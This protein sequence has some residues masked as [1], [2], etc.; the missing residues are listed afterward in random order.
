MI[1]ALERRDAATLRE[2]LAAHLRAKRDAVIEQL[3]A[4]EAPGTG[5]VAR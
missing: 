5:E 2:L 4:G 3:R 1:V